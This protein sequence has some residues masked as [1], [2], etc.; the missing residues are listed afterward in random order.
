MLTHPEE[1]FTLGPFAADQLQLRSSPESSCPL[2][3]VR[4]LQEH[5]EVKEQEDPEQAEHQRESKSCI[6]LK[7]PDLLLYNL[8]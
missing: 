3:T 5:G 2:P 7:A 4:P 1:F 6:K 8:L